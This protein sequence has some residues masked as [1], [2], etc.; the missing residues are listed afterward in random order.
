MKGKG[1]Y[2]KGPHS[3]DMYLKQTAIANPHVRYDRSLKELPPRPREIKPRRKPGPEG[4][5]TY[6]KP[7]CRAG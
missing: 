1:H 6:L 5:G 4:N 7:K 3:I 2:Q